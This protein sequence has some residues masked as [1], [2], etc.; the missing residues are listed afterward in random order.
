MQIIW[1]LQA[2]DRYIELELLWYELSTKT[3]LSHVFK[4]KIQN[5]CIAKKKKK[6]S[7]IEPLIFCIKQWNHS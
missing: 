2:I 3:L 5:L 4:I 6:I 7:Y 1:V